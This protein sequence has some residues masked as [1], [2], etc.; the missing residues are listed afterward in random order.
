[1]GRTGAQESQALDLF[2]QAEKLWKKE[3]YQESE[4]LYLKANSLSPTW[5]QMKDLATNKMD[6]RDI[7]GAN[8]IWDISINSLAIKGKGKDQ[9]LAYWFKMQENINKGSSK[10]AIETGIQLLKN[11]PEGQ[12]NMFGFWQSP[13]MSLHFTTIVEMA[14]RMEDRKSL[15]I[16]KDLLKSHKNTNDIDFYISIYL[17]MLD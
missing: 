4:K 11:P 10:V 17:K 12:D 3:Q 1:M 9:Y 16:L 2:K 6:M 15:V 14:F 13:G 7:K 5:F 8:R